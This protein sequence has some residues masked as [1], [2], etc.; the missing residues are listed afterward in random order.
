MRHRS[1][2]F[3]LRLPS[4]LKNAVTEASEQDNTSIN[5]LGLILIT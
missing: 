5:R 3:P 2:T 4:S 1:S